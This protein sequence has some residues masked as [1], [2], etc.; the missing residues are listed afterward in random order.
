MDSIPSHSSTPSSDA[1]TASETEPAGRGASVFDSLRWRIAVSYAGLL[2]IAA[3]VLLFFVNAAA[4]LATIPTEYGT[5]SDLVHGFRYTGQFVDLQAAA[6][7]QDTLDRL[8]FYS[9]IAFAVVICAGL[10]IGW[11]VSGRALRPIGQMAAVA[12]RVSERNLS[13]RI[14]LPGPA[15]ELKQLADSFDAMVGR[16]DT[17]FAHERQLV[18]DASH[19]LRT[20]LTALQLTLDEVRSDP[21]ATLDD[22]KRV[23]AEAA[24]STA[25]MRRLVQD[26][27]ALADT[28]QPPAPASVALAPLVDAVIE[29]LEPLAERSSIMVGSAVP[30]GL[31]ARADADSLQRA[32]RNLVENAIRYNHENGHVMVEQAAAPPG[33]VALAVRDNGIGIPEEHRERIFDRFYRVDRSRSRGEGGSGLGL[34]IVAKVVADLGG[35]VQVESEPG[36]GSRFVITV[37]VPEVTQR[38]NPPPAPTLATAPLST[39]GAP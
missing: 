2:V 35:T 34:A 9:I 20:P 24:V 25:R 12:R 39:Q 17:A 38:P 22:Y 3:G 21:D 30:A 19:E 6:A 8:R 11:V 18:A 10:V 29:E 32:L 7:R 36:K 13:E 5:T 27:L 15:D 26:L 14:D 16:L 33:W 23:A 1:A 4:R 37:P 31:V 28:G